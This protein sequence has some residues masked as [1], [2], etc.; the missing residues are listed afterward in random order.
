M[1]KVNPLHRAHTHACIVE[2]QSTWCG[3]VNVLLIEQ[4]QWLVTQRTEASSLAS[5]LSSILCHLQY[6]IHKWKSIEELGRLPVTLALV[7]VPHLSSMVMASAMVQLSMKSHLHDY[8]V[9]YWKRLYSGWCDSNRCV[10]QVYYSLSVLFLWWSLSMLIDVK[11]IHPGSVVH[12]YSQ[13]CVLVA[14]PQPLHT[15]LEEE[16][17]LAATLYGICMGSLIIFLNMLC[18]RM[19]NSCEC[20]GVNGNPHSCA[21]L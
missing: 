13:H 8:K 11:L 18:D 19:T 10:W 6:W 21:N 14:A 12:V 7:L 20:I 2:V 4:S 16:D 5:C 3:I 1:G 15:D 9:Q 17:E